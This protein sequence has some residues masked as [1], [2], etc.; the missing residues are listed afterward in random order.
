MP[1]KL[2]DI[3]FVDLLPGSISGD[4]TVRD[5]ASALDKE[6]QTV[7]SMLDVPTLLSRLDELPEPAVD[8]LAWQFHV[9]FWD[10]DME[11]PEKREVVRESI[12]WH[13]HK[14]TPWAVKHLLAKVGFTDADVIEFWQARKQYKDEGGAHLDGSWTLGGSSV[15]QLVPYKAVTGLP[16]MGHWAE[17]CVRLNLTEARW[18]GWNK[19]LIQAVNVAKPARSWPVWLYWLYL[20]VLAQPQHTYRLDL[21]KAVDLD[22]PWCTPQLDGNWALG[23]GGYLYTLNGSLQVDGAWS[24]GQGTETVAD[25][26]LKQCNIFYQLSLNKEME[27][28]ARYI[29]ARL[30]ESKL[31]VNGGWQVGFNS[32]LALSS[33]SLQKAVQLDLQARS[34]ASQSLYLDL[35]YPASPQ[36]LDTRPK[37]STWRSLDAKWRLSRTVRGARL[38]GDWPIRRKQGL[39]SEYSAN[40]TMFGNIGPSF[41]LG[42]Y[43][44]VGE[45]WNRRLDGSWYVGAFHDI[46]GSWRLQNGYLLGGRKIGKHYQDLDGSWRLGHTSKK[47]G[48]FA[49]G[50]PGVECEANIKIH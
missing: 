3:S 6:L 20:V 30:G 46:D 50:Q 39:P 4:K 35:D 19:D 29:A 48:G 31:S 43:S 41:S 16:Y 47:L 49:L 18:P 28:P 38:S 15:K 2:S 12:A 8:L 11:L 45:H 7:N 22:Y 34:S 21:S 5:A 14:G 25:R 42:S 32:V 37:L 24:L 10:S 13:K 36:S 33:A 9:D 17:F 23:S 27:R 26:Q 1:K 44:K 40:Y